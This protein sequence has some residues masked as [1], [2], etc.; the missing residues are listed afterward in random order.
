[1][2]LFL[3][4]T[5]ISLSWLG[6]LTAQSCEWKWYTECQSNSSDPDGSFERLVYDHQFDLNAT[7][8]NDLANGACGQDNQLATR[9]RL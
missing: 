6:V 2:S 5:L 7:N 3:S 9:F 1:M 8:C 4:L